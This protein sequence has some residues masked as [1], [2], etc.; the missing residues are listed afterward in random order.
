MK[1]V[2]RLLAS[3]PAAAMVFFAVL[4]WSSISAAPA[5]QPAPLPVQPH[6]QA[7]PA[8]SAEAPQQPGVITEDELR[9]LFVG[10]IFYLRGGYLDSSLSFDEHGGI[11]GHSPQGS[12]TLSMIKIVS[13]RLSKHKVELDG[14]RY[15]LH[16]LGALAYENPTNAV[17]RVRITPPK[18][19]LHITVDREVEVNPKKV[20]AEKPS[21]ST[22]PAV[23]GSVKTQTVGSEAHASAAV[24]AVNSAQVLKSALANVF[25]AELDARMI[26]AMPEF[27]KLYYQAADAKTDYQPSDPAVQRQSAVETKA[28]LVS[29]IQP[30][31]NEYAQQ[32]GVAGIALYHVVVGADGTPHEIVVGRPIGFG[33]DENAVLA[34]RKAKFQ[35]AIK[36]GKLVP[37][38]IDLVVEF[39]IYSKRTA[40]ADTVPKEAEQPG[41]STLPGPYSNPQ[42]Q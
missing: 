16:F 31:S 39:R 27:W 1:A 38:L 42:R 21:K 36:D 20:K 13:L 18:K 37:V 28:R 3:P 35:P 14:I 6:L 8:A 32:A 33:L 10:K 9:Q 11:I 17:D 4:A 29:D 26:T 12:Y 41:S 7:A 22:K 24:P 25:A 19:F 15:G 23:S 30:E 40:A 34:I 2:L 5:Q